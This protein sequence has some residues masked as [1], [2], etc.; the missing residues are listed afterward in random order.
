MKWIFSKIQNELYLIFSLKYMGGIELMVG[1]LGLNCVFCWWIFFIILMKKI[2]I[3]K[4][5]IK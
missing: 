1:C 5:G 4:S 2:I 3:I